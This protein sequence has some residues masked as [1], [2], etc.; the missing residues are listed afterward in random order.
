MSIYDG[1]GKFSFYF[2]PHFSSHFLVPSFQKN[3]KLLLLGIVPVFWLWHTCKMSKTIQSLQLNRLLPAIRNDFSNTSEI[4]STDASDFQ[5]PL[6]DVL[7]SGLAMMFLQDPSLLEFQRRLEERRRNNNLKTIFGVENVPKETQFRDILDSADPSEVQLP[8]K[9][10]IHALQQTRLW[11]KFRVLDGRYA[12]L[13]DGFEFFR[14]DKCGCKHCLENKHKDGRVDYAHKCLAVTLA[15]PTIKLP[16]PILLEEIK[17]EDGKVKQDCEFN[18]A[19]RV[20]PALA[21]FYPHLDMIIIGDGLFSKTP[22]V[23]EA[24]NAGLSY[25]F[26]AK[27]SDHTTLEKDLAGL[28]TCEGVEKLEIKASDGTKLVYEWAKNIELNGSSDQKTN[29]FGYTEISAKGQI[30]YRNSWVTNIKPTRKNIQELVE[31]GRHRWQ[32]ENQAFNVLKNH[33][34]H[35]EHN[36]GHGKN[37]LAFIFIV[38]NF[39]AYMLHQ[40]LRLADKLLVAVQERMG[41]RYRLWDDIRVLFNHFV[42]GSWD[43]LLEHMLDY[44]DDTG[45][46]SG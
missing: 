22:M 33:G 36:F 3:V 29:W 32:I 38:L 34:H 26:V 30:I 19:K 7:M 41:T 11:S 25:I 18:A 2:L 9:T 31:V 39:L 45:L 14:S 8:F 20:I 23:L 1:F 6:A 4:R 10:L 44:R 15:H 21:K 27:P 35:L 40:I 43:A 16:I 5:Y 13:M 46:E 42:W 17:Q 37:N 24:L 28:R 12:V